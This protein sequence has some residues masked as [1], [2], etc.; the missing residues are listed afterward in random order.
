MKKL[1]LILLLFA[2][3]SS[4]AQIQLSSSPFQ[5]GRKVIS[6]CTFGDPKLGYPPISGWY[7][8]VLP[9]NLLSASKSHDI[10]TD[11]WT[12]A[13]E[14]DKMAVRIWQ[15]NNAD[16]T[17]AMSQTVIREQ[18]S[19]I[20]MILFTGDSKV[21]Y[22]CIVRLSLAERRFWI[23]PANATPDDLQRQPTNQDLKV[24]TIT[25]LGSDFQP[26]TITFDDFVG[27]NHN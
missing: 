4:R 26:Y 27:N 16:W 9:M 6:F 15:T 14:G 2:T 3:I 11:V 17:A 22:K 5:I 7:A 12:G 13:G 1:I 18:P 21:L 10:P 19:F 23:Y 8:V 25:F 20:A 24:K